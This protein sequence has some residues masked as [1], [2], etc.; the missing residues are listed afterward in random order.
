MAKRRSSGGGSSM[1]LIMTLVFFI[2]TTV[3]LGVTTYMGYA[4]VKDHD[5][6]RKEA[7]KKEKEAKLEKD[8]YKFQMLVVREYLG[9]GYKSEKD[10]DNFRS[11]LAKDKATFDKSGNVENKFGKSPT[12]A[13]EFKEVVEKL[14]KMLFVFDAKD[15]RQPEPWKAPDQPQPRTNF[16]DMLAKLDGKLKKANDKSVELSG[17]LKDLQQKLTDQKAETVEATRIFNAG[18]KKARDDAEGNRKID[19]AEINKLT[20]LL[21]TANDEKGKAETAR[22]P[23]RCS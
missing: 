18:I 14:D 23:C 22:G 8:W 20:G 13:K 1:G 5:D 11:L 9:E 12:D 6:K 3:T 17:E 7:E 16:I 4:E 15:D 21:A 19:R 10:E 2:L